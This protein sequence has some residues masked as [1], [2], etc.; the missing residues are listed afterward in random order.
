[1][2]TVALLLVSLISFTWHSL[3][4]TDQPRGNL[5]ELHSCELYAGGCVVSSQATLGGRYMLRA[6]NFTGGAFAGTPLAGLSVAVLQ[7]SGENLAS[8]DSDAGQAVVYLPKAATR[9]Q[10]QTLFAWLKTTQADLKPA[11]LETRVVPLRFGQT[12]AGYAFTAGTFISVKTAPLE[13]CGT[14][15]CGESLWYTPRAAATEFTVLLDRASQV[16]EPLLQLKWADAGK[17]SI[18]VA[19]FG[20]DSSAQT[21]RVPAAHFCGLGDKPF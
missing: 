9:G 17:R 8:P 5:L 21:G 15:G 19:R 18:F 12:S 7:M 4:A 6:W 16:T 11:A 3:W 20:D 10:R 13:S 1:M 2:R 14:G